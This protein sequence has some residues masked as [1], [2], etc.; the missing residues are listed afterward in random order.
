M[1]DAKLVELTMDEM[2]MTVGGFNWCFVAGGGVGLLV[3]AAVTIGTGG[4][5]FAIGAGITGYA[6][7]KC[8]G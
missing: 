5:G 3:G 8:A 1:K 4:A 7:A 2:M 6:I